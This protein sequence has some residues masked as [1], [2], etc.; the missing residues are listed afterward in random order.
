M[1][2]VAFSS[3]PLAGIPESVQNVGFGRPLD[4]LL[5]VFVAAG[6]GQGH[7]HGLRAAGAGLEAK[8]GPAVVYLRRHKPERRW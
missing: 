8:D 4:G 5:V 1:F 3:Q 2:R 6:K 7:E